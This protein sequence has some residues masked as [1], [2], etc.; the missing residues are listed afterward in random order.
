M[1][2][3]S[4]IRFATSRPSRVSTKRFLLVSQLFGL[5]LLT[6]L[7]SSLSLNVLQGGGF[8]AVLAALASLIGPAYCAIWL[9]ERWVL[10]RVEAR[11]ASEVTD[12]VLAEIRDVNTPVKYAWPTTRRE[13]AMVI[14]GL[15]PDDEDEDDAR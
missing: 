9:L 12:R 11:R 5:V 14:P 3:L 10:T 13:P 6:G 15:V 1:C 7:L 2:M 8:F 4:P